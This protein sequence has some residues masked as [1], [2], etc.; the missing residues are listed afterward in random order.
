MVLSHRQR[1]QRGFTIVELL[2]VIVVIGILAALVLN[3]FSGVQAKA[4]DVK[5]D[6][7]IKALSTQLE[8][9]YSQAG[10]GSY[11]SNGTAGAAY[12]VGA[13]AGAT[14]VNLDNDADITAKFK[15]IDLNST[16]AP[17]QTSNSM[18]F[19]VTATALFANAPASPTNAGTNGY[20]YQ[21]LNAANTICLTESTCTHFNLYYQ[22][23]A[24]VA[25]VTK[26]SLNQ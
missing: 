7:D 2:I 4:R 25:L 11:P 9:F 5:R 1:G 18:F 16:R 6:T 14:S 13:F 21:P 23:E 10:N 19:G 15:G 17:S 3:S 24:A 26:S 8:V 12:A 20:I 22:R